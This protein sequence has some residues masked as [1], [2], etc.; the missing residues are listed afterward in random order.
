MMERPAQRIAGRLGAPL[1]ESHDSG[2][3]VKAIPNEYNPEEYD[4]LNV[5]TEIKELFKYI[6]RFTP[7]EIELDTK[8]KVFVPEFIPTIG[9]VDGFLK[10]DKPE[11]KTEDLGLVSLVNPLFNLRTNQLLISQ[12]KQNLIL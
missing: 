4:H 3:G 5:S 8:L 7:R 6:T 2:Q 10:M 1:N 9:E 12:R 11:S